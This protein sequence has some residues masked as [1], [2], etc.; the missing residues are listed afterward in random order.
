[1]FAALIESPPAD[2]AA[3][4][5][6]CVRLKFTD[7]TQDIPVPEGTTILSAA[8]AAGVPMVSQCKI[9]NCGTCVG[10][11]STG[12]VV[13]P[14]GRV[15][16]LRQ[17]EMADGMRLLCQAHAV[18]DAEIELDYSQAMLAENPVMS[19]AVKVS[20]LT[21]LA[22]TVVELTVRVPKSTAFGFRAGQYVRLRV[23]GTE[24]WRSYSM[25][26]GE[27][28]RR[29]LVFN[30]RVLPQGAMSDYLRDR[31][32]V[33][34]QL[35]VE[36][37]MGSF[38]L[39]SEPGPALMIAGGTGLAPMLSMLETLQPARQCNEIRLVFGCAR[40][41]DLFHLDEL[42]ARQSFMRDL[43]VRVVLDESVDRAGI[44]VGNPVSVLEAE[45]I[46]DP[47]T[48]AYLCGPPGMLDAAR[49]RLHELGMPPERI[50][51]EQFLPS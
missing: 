27:R 39:S 25:A 11:V 51:A 4:A 36:G 37:P 22:P 35:E 32:A 2:Q 38:G 34:D 42:D 29:Q 45:D 15:Y 24:E 3:V 50:H 16:P 47:R 46:A 7:T 17:G 40:E 44:L 12:N 30:I 41:A 10:R 8:D 23:P 49:A 1:M 43:S 19:T 31:A 26:S 48:S 28:Q 33:G 6:R 5:T 13:M 14:E 21:W 9:G 18:G 20:G